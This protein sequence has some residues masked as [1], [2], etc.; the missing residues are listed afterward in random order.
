MYLKGTGWNGTGWIHLA[1]YMDTWMNLSNT[2]MKLRVSQNAGNFLD[3]LT[4]YLL[5]KKN[6]A[7][8]MLQVRQ[9]CVTVTGVYIQAASRALN[10]WG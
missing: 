1:Q 7:P 6:S 2:V 9:L 3:R 5:H 4:A 10:L 8:W